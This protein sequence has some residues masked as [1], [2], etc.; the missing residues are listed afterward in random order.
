MCV[1][2]EVACQ[3]LT[4]VKLD[5]GTITAS[6][7][8][9]AG[10]FIPP[11][12]ASS[13]G[14]ASDS[15]A[16]AAFAKLPA[17]CR[18]QAT[19]KP[20]PDSTIHIEVWMPV[21]GWNGKLVESGNGAFT[22]APTYGAMASSLMKGYAATGSDTGHTGNTAD[23]ALGHPE[24][25]IDFGYRAVHLNALA[26]RAIVQAHLGSL[27]KAYFVGCSTGGRQ[28]YGE[29]QRYPA[30]FDGIVAG[31]PGINFTH[32]TA[33]E[34]A[35]VKH[36]HN[37]PA[38]FMDAAKLKMLHSAVIAACDKLDGVEDG[39]IENPLRCKFD[40][41]TLL[42]KTGDGPDC[43]TAPQVALVRKIYSG[44]T[45]S[46]GKIIFPGL[47]TGTEVL[48]GRTLIR[49]EPMEY[50]LDAYR[51]VVMQDPA[52]NYLALELDRDIPAADEKVGAVMNNY[53]PNLK[54][55]FER[56][57]KLLGYQGW[58]DGMN[59]PLN[60]IGYYNL[61]AEMVGGEKAMSNDYRLF[62]VPG[63][64]H[65]GGGDGTTSFDLLSEV[66]EWVTTGKAPH[67]IPA[68]RIRAG[69]V[70]RTRPLCAYPQQAVYKGSGS[71]D[72]TANFACA[73]R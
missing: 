52:W 54:P 69:A 38:S 59:S 50:G 6:Q 73:V 13:T 28:A 9:K 33:A 67:S 60:H 43:L 14:T 49:T 32:Q 23:F 17:F 55:F 45:N 51:D 64:E 10:E 71:I 31:A 29:A 18:V 34:L 39:V 5:G 8:V 16:N 62:L 63:M 12:A 35:I 2:A 46:S 24:R 72:D 61:V 37:E 1:N 20:V 26:A 40:P 42:C 15:S 27:E 21:S 56:G 70:D 44:V 30:D 57:G 48:W 19:L 41:D 3:K 53:D 58:A 7:T 36:V 4:S 22:G 11:V 66:D 68:S 65:C 47:P 25:L